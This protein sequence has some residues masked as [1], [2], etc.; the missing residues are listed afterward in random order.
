MSELLPFQKRDGIMVD[1]ETLSTRPYASII[2]IGACRFS[3]SGFKIIDTFKVNID[4][5]SCKPLGMHFCPDTMAWW[6]SQPREL[7]K[8][9]FNNQVPISEAI[10]MLS[11]W[12]V[13]DTMFW[14]NGISFDSS[15]LSNAYFQLNM[16]KPWDYWDEMDLRTV[17]HMVGFSNRKARA[18]KEGHH[19]ALEDAK[20]QTKQLLEFFGY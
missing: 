8:G 20:E 11:D 7:T 17:Y 5:A 4:P 3:F 2:S 12:W 16:K 6:K 1:L 10:S 15:I 13:N 14:A 18:G 19:D 9:V